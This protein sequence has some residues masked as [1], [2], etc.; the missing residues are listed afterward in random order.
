[1]HSLRDVWTIFNATLDFRSTEASNA[2]ILT[3]I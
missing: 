1:M 3:L 2:P